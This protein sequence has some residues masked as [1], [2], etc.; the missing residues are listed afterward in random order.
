VNAPVSTSERI[1]ELNDAFRTSGPMA[2]GWMLTCGVQSL[3]PEFVALAT[4]AVQQ[5]CRFTADNDPYGEHDFGS[6]NLGGEHLFWK[7]DH[8]DRELVFGSEDPSNPAV[9]RR[10][11]TIMLASEY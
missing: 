8:Y 3:G 7:I 6:F 9:T 1:R 5:R 2:G 10:I 11:M 4:R